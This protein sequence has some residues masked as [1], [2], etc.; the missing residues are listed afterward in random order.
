M[1][2]YKK[3]YLAACETNRELREAAVQRELAIGRLKQNHD[4]LLDENVNLGKIAETCRKKEEA[5]LMK[6]GALEGEVAALEEE[7]AKAKHD[8]LVT[9]EAL[10]SANGNLDKLNAD[11]A[12]ML[13]HEGDCEG[14]YY[15]ATKNY[16]KCNS[17]TRNTKAV[18]KYISEAEVEAAAGATI[19]EVP[20]AKEAASAEEVAELHEDSVVIQSAGVQERSEEPK[21]VKKAKKRNRKKK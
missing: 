5:A 20:T 19:G 11:I 2:K 9:A 15:K 1:F 21:P 4:A 18:D 6:V 8:N 17:C 10:A 14:C 7:L 13:A 3:R 12:D 16:R